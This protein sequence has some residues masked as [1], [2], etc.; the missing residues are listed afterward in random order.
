MI[1]RIQ[2]SIFNILHSPR[3][4]FTLVEVLVSIGIFTVL[5]GVVLSNYRGYNTN[6]LFANASEDIVLALRQ[7]QVYGVGVKGTGTSFT[8]PYG[9]HF[10]SANPNQIIIFADIDPPAAP[11]SFP[12]D[13]IYTAGNDTNIE[14]INWSGVVS[15][16]T[17]RCNGGPCGGNMA[18]ITFRR[19]NPDAMIYDSS[20]QHSSLEVEITNNVKT[21]RIIISNTGQISLQ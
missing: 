13:G 19:P 20:V 15:L 6:A 2:H 18:N 17:L 9:V 12:G 1:K 21:S 14:T 5:T 4:G 16:M 3:K 7:A 8:T 10:N 11:L